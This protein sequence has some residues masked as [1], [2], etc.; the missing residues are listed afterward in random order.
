MSKA[1]VKPDKPPATRAYRARWKVDLGD[2]VIQPGETVDLTEAE[3]N[4]C[5]DAVEPEPDK[6]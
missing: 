6:G 2:R 4:A 5:G 1:P 3:A